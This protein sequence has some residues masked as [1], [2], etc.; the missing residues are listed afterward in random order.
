MIIAALQQSAL[1]ANDTRSIAVAA[2]VATLMAGAITAI[3]TALAPPLALV[4]R[5]FIDRR[6]SRLILMDEINDLRRH[7]SAN[8]EILD[9]ILARPGIPARM[10]IE[11]MR[12]FQSNLIYDNTV[13][14]DIQPKI[15]R[16]LIRLRLFV[17]NLDFEIDDTVS[18]L[19]GQPAPDYVHVREQLTYLREK[20]LYAIARLDEDTRELKRERG[21][22]PSARRP[23][24][25]IY[26]T[27]ALVNEPDA[28]LAGGGARAA[29]E[30]AGPRG[31]R[32]G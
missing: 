11:K 21:P 2:V 22:P 23:Q 5:R 32:A 10:H 13:A 26:R 27:G 3:G 4:F 15:R 24:R 20:L 30:T 18:F 9:L 1:N 17:R 14:F 6:R 19:Y 25:I 12:M 8:L 7:C 31:G 28:L 16:L 29:L